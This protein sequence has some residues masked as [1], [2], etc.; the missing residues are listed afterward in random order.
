MHNLPKLV[1][2]TLLMAMPLAAQAQ[3]DPAPQGGPAAEPAPQMTPEQTENLQRGVRIM[4]AFTAAFESEQVADAVKGRLIVC[5]YA[6]N[7]NQISTEAGKVFANNPQLDPTSPQDLYRA[8]AGVCGV[9]FRPVAAAGAG[10]GAGGT[11][12]PAKPVE[13]APDGGR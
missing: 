5:L 10:G 9:S 3:N 12:T 1:A 7:L 6:R 11:K 2:V 13:P 4:R 8:A